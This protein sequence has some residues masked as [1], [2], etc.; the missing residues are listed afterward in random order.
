MPSR[1]YPAAAR[2]RHPGAVAALAENHT[3]AD[4]PAD[5]VPSPAA[6]DPARPAAV[7]A[8][9]HA[10]EGPH[11]RLFARRWQVAPAASPADAVTAAGTGAATPLAPVVLLHDS[12]GCVALW[13]DFP[14]ALCRAT[15]RDVVA[16]DR[17]GFG[18][19]DPRTGPLPPGFVAE[20][21]ARTWPAL[22]EQLGIGRFVALGHSVG[23]G[24]AIHVAARFP[25]DCEAL[26]TIA[27]QAFTED[28]TLAGIRAARELF[29]GDAAQF[30][31]LA[32]HHGPRARWVLDAWTETW[33]DPRFASWTLEDVLP[34]V[35]CPVLALHGEQDEYGSS[36]HP[37]MIAARAGGPSRAVL[38][39]G[40]GHVPQREQP[41][42]VI[43]LLARFLADP[44]AVAA[45]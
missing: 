21:A 4:S 35:A 39:P 5:P 30:E 10:V 15:G 2:L 6:P 8:Q 33:L 16:Y 7:V 40:A 23:G 28:I 44:S 26:V 43:A 45:R 38:L 1:D 41:E 9:D 19:S 31:R 29:N 27:A 42:A 17:A 32:R 11:G 37:A 13:R 20:E 25:G 3:H 18:R 22:R 34:R 14:E 36:R 24:M 12:L